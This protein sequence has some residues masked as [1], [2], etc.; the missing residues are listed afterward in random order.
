MGA[1]LFSDIVYYQET[2]FSIKT[3]EIESTL[4][5]SFVD[6]FSRLTSVH[7]IGETSARGTFRRFKRCKKDCKSSR[8]IVTPSKFHRNK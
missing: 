7:E 5:L 4:D 2:D 1:I 6:Y 8:D 3:I